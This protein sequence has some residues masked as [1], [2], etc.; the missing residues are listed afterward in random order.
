MKKDFSKFEERIG[1]TF[2]DKNL[3]KQA[4]VH[5]SYINENRAEK[6]EHNERIEFLGDAV[7]ELVVTNHLFITYPKKSEG[8]LTALRSALVNTQALA[9][10]A[11]ELNINDFL[12]LSK[13]ESRDNGRAR[14]YILADTFEAIIGAIYIDQGLEKSA[15]FI[16]ATILPRLDQ[17]LKEKLWQDSKS[18]FQEKA[19]NK[20]GIT[21]R[22]K[23]LKE[24]GPDHDKEFVIAVYLDKE[25]VAEGEG[26]SKQEAEQDAAERA[27]DT[28]EW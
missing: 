16:E 24:T 23:T 6:L 22:Y 11:E 21:P 3:L 10:A 1:Y 12:L 19:Q 20:T 17:V 2:S 18:H 5:R 9:I 7:L 13:G 15:A 28:K 8:E 4:F 26:R 14:K 27:L 25:K